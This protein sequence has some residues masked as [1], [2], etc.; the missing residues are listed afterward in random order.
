MKLGSEKLRYIAPGL[1]IVMFGIDV[2]VTS[3]GDSP[4][5]DNNDSVCD[6]NNPNVDGS[7]RLPLTF[8]DTDTVA[9]WLDGFK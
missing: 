6:P 1:E 2:I 5:Y 4:P 3:S 8:A 9:D 7:G